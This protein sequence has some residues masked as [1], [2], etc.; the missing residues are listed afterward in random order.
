MTKKVAFSGFIHT[1]S[2]RQTFEEEI[3]RVIRYP[4]LPNQ[5]FSSLDKI[6]IRKIYET[7]NMNIPV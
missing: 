7:D 5:E 3:I 1:S 4:V 6:V 2:F